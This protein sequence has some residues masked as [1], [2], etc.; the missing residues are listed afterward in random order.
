MEKILT[1]LGD[2]SRIEMTESE[3]QQIWKMVLKMLL[4]EP[5]YRP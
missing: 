5:M 3:V 2:G 4:R 1:R